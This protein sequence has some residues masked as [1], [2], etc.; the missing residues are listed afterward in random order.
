[1]RFLAFF[2]FVTYVWVLMLFAYAAF[3]A[4]YIQSNA[5]VT[6]ADAASLTQARSSIDF[7]N[8]QSEMAARASV[9]EAE[10]G[11]SGNVTGDITNWNINNYM[12]AYHVFGVLWTNQ[13]IHAVAFITMSGCV[14]SAYWV[15]DPRHTPKVH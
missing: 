7:N 11:I 12:Q 1:M 10:G 4:A 9:P 2:P 13:L 14:G 5:D 6:V 3:F 15:E 8:L